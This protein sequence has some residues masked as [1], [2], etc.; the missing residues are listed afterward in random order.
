VPS[1]LIVDDNPLIRA[2]LRRMLQFSEDWQVCGE[3]DGGSSALRLAENQRPDI[4]LMDLSMPGMDGLEATQR[5]KAKFPGTKILLL[6]A[7]VSRGLAEIAF[8]AGV[9]GYV[10]KASTRQELF[11][12][13]K[14][15]KQGEIYVSPAI[16]PVEAQDL[17]AEDELK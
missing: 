4:V 15:I 9:N 16:S 10:V 7:H 5:I 12:A 2:G 6:T 1:V 3:A 14:A 8:R 17:V 11:R 13:M